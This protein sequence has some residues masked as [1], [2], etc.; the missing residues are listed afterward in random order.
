M[1]AAMK[2]D[3]KAVANKHP[4]GLFCFMVISF[5]L[6]YDDREFFKQTGLPGADLSLGS[7]SICD[8]SM[9]ALL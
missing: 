6:S 3:K 1:E 4:S 9:M 8:G 7:L 2:I 5:S